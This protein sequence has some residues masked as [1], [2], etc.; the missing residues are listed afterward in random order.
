MCGSVPALWMCSYHVELT[1]VSACSTYEAWNTR[2]SSTSRQRKATS[3]S[4][5]ILL[6]PG[7][8]NDRAAS[9]PTASS[10]TKG[11]QTL[12][13]APPLLRLAA[14]PHDAHLL[15]TFAAD[16]NLIRILDVRQPGTALLELRGHQADLRSIEWNPSRR[17]ML[18]SGADDSTVLI[19][20]LLN[21]QNQ[22]SVPPAANGNG[23]GGEPTA[24]GPFASWRCE[25]EV[26]NV[27]WSPQSTLT[28]QGGDWL[29]VCAGRGVWGVKL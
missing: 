6:G 11:G 17:G 4:Y 9:S 28:Q 16:S 25:Y 21:S 26:A 20:D 13:P 8:T 19:W 3:V 18:A 24:K 5:A 29:G 2:Q 27:S 10:P 14:S 12:S 23:T 22:A 1:A 15:A 7:C